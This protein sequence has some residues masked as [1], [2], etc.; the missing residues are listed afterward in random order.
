MKYLPADTEFSKLGFEPIEIWKRRSKKLLGNSQFDTKEP[1]KS[2]QESTFLDAH[3]G[4]DGATTT[5][6]RK[7]EKIKEI[8]FT[9]KLPS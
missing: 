5:N 1:F 4:P 8:A 2:V 3:V 6:P 7:T 9:L